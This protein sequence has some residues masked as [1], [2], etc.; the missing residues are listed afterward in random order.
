MNLAVDE[1]EDRTLRR[2]TGRIAFSRTFEKTGLTWS[3]E[4]EITRRTWLVA[5]C[6][7]CDSLT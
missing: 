5:V 1:T 4:L 2:G 6:C 7:S 3:R